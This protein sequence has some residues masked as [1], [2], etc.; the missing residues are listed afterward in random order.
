MDRSTAE[1]LSDELLDEIGSADP[2]RWAGVVADF[3]EGL[4]WA[5][6]LGDVEGWMEA[7]L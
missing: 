5:I 1:V 2:S 3:L 4:A 6:E 7:R